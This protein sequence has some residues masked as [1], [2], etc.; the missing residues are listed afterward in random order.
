[1][2][3]SWDD[4]YSRR[5]KIAQGIQ[6]RL[7]LSFSFSVK[8]RFHA[9]SL[10]D[11]MLADQPM[12]RVPFYVIAR[13]MMAASFDLPPV[14][15]VIDHAWWLL[16]DNDTKE[17]WGFVTEPYITPSQAEWLAELMSRQHIDWGIGVMVLPQAQSAWNPG[18]T[19][20]IVVM[21]SAGWL[22]RFLRLGVGAALEA[23]PPAEAG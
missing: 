16:V 15:T 21:S 7:G 18:S 22:T 12:W 23:I 5:K 3:F 19:V 14:G 11:R 17:P 13:R 10:T 9:L 1:M 6:K 4:I 8:T 20:P 2:T